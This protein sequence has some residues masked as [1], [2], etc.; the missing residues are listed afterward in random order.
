MAKNNDFENM[1]I[2]TAL[3]QIIKQ[4]RNSHL[5]VEFWKNS[6]PQLEYLRTQLNLSNMQIVFISAML[7]WDMTMDWKDFA[8][9]LDITSFEVKT[10]VHEL[11]NL[12]IKEWVTVENCLMSDGLGYKISSAAITALLNNQAFVP[13]VPSPS[14]DDKPTDDNND[15]IDC[16]AVDDNDENNCNN[17]ND[18]G[19]S[20]LTAHTEVRE[21][22]LFYNPSEQK[23]VKHLA[24]M[25]SPKNFS[26]IQHR[27]EEQ[28]MRKGFA[29][30]FYGGPGTGKTETV[31]QIARQTGRDIMQVD[32]SSIRDR[33]VGGT[34]KNIKNV[35]DSYRE[36]CED[37][38]V[39]PILLFN[40]ADGIFSKRSTRL[41]QYCDKEENAMQNIILQ[42]MET[43]DG[44]LIATTNLTC[45][46]DKAFERRFLYKIEFT[47]PSVEVKAKIW[48]SMIDRLGK[49]SALHL[50]A[51]Y[52]FS[53][54]QIEN[55]A[56]KRAVDYALYGKYTSL[57]Q[58]EE[59]CRTEMSP[60]E[61][62]KSER[63]H[64]LGFRSCA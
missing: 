8:N 33:F 22:S 23:Q 28:K 45:N 14:K 47:K 20:V 7:E 61:T 38:E 4:A 52:D 44:I 11:E 48:R 24:K 64:I 50:A 26:A 58:I 35:F 42:E 12:V 49:K 29:C 46:M 57:A 3:T 32:I 60:K 19:L 13:E 25:L 34:L 39:T 54:G 9:Y 40:E 10:Y 53:G 36:I 51:T 18:D 63:H 31:L 59:Y 62:K 41:Q 6:E 1:T 27:L 17:T 16:K 56:R 21:K 55:I 15:N 30:L 2:V 5:S 37:S 43:F